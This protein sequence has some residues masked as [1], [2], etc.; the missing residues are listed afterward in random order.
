VLSKFYQEIYNTYH[1]ASNASLHYLVNICISKL[2]KVTSE[3]NL[4]SRIFV[5]IQAYI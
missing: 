2:A 3:Q 5:H 1:F 4:S